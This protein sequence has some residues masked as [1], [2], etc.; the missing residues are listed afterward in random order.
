MNGALRS[1]RCL[2]SPSGQRPPG[3]PFRVVRAG[4]ARCL[5][6]PTGL[7]QP[8]RP[9]RVVRA[10]SGRGAEAVRHR[11]EGLAAL[12]QLTQPGKVLLHLAGQCRGHA[13]TA[14]LLLDLPHHHIGG[15][16]AQHVEQTFDATTLDD[17]SAAFAV[18]F[19]PAAA[20]EKDLSAKFKFAVCQDEACSP[21][22]EEFQ[23]KLAVK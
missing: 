20:G 4:S 14:E 9:F 16:A 1:A 12:A 17:K 19:T 23:V 15:R 13:N 6:S 11:A 5:V 21:V 3:R 7:R 2:V 10:G 18:K 22:T 8:G